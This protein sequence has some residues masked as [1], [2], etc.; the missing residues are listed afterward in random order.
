MSDGRSPRGRGVRGLGDG[1][2]RA[3]DDDA[4]LLRA[5]CLV[6]SLCAGAIGMIHPDVIWALAAWVLVFAGLVVA[7]EA[8]RRWV[9]DARR[10]RRAFGR[11]WAGL[12]LL[13]WLPCCLANRAGWFSF[14][15]PSWVYGSGTLLWALLSFYQ[16]VLGLLWTARAA[17]DLVIV[18]R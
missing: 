4:R 17:A 15:F 11:C 3:A 5:F 1:G 13:L 10:Q 16:R 8:T 14:T 12:W 7:R 9:R 6:Q 2:A 18:V